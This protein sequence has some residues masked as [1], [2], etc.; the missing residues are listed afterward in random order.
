MREHDFRQKL[1]IEVTMLDSWVS[2]GWLIPVTTPQ[3]REFTDADLAR[4]LLIRDL[5]HDMGVNE[6][7]VDVAIRLIDQ[8]HGLRQTLHGLVRA[9]DRHDRRLRD[10]L[11]AEIVDLD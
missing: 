7:G 6:A 4:A 2:H 1:R 10:R 3:G 8:M 11:I 5:V 9:M